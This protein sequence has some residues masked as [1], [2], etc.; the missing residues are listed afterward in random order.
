[1]SRSREGVLRLALAAA[2]FAA[3]LVIGSLLWNRIFLPFENPWG[4]TGPLTL[5]SFNP[6][7]NVIRFIVFISVPFLCLTAA[8]IISGWRLRKVIFPEPSP[9]VS[10]AA[11]GSRLALIFLVLF[12]ALV[13]LN[14]P[15]RELTEYVDTFHEGESIGMAIS[16]EAGL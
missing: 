10:A 14:Y 2:L 8:Y 4:A 11:S 7:N 6:A 1:M 9:Y 13:S 12:S 5:I 16:Y 15:E 3:G